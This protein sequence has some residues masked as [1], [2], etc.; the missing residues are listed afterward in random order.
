MCW[1]TMQCCSDVYTRGVRLTNLLMCHV[2]NGWD[3]PVNNKRLRHANFFKFMNPDCRQKYDNLN[4]LRVYMCGI[5][6]ADYTHMQWI[7]IKALGWILCR[8]NV[9]IQAM[10][11]CSLSTIGN[12]DNRLFGSRYMASALSAVMKVYHNISI[13]SWWVYNPLQ[14][15]MVCCV[16][17]CSRLFVYLRDSCAFTF[18]SWF[19]DSLRRRQMTVM[20]FRITGQSS[21]CS[22][23]GSLRTYRF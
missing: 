16:L 4:T 22:I 11:L 17:F 20:A 7:S 23:F 2:F 9:N 10:K 5:D 21:L 12:K 6:G 15:L 1:V 19:I 3:W 18:Q 8:V 14:V 13:K